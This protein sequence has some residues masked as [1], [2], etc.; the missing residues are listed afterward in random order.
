MEESMDNPCPGFG[1]CS[2]L[3][4]S[5]LD[6]R[7]GTVS[8]M[9]FVQNRIICDNCGEEV[10]NKTQLLKLKKFLNLEECT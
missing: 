6:L 10:T 9:F 8:Y 5:K 7:V 1:N 3:L 4:G 2:L